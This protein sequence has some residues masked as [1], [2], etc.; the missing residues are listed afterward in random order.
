MESV[1]FSSCECNQLSLQIYENLKYKKHHCFAN[2]ELKC[3]MVDK[4]Y[5]VEFQNSMGNKQE[6]GT[7][8]VIFLHSVGCNEWL[9]N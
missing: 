3:E 4:T 2:L 6:I 9:I 5:I 8:R 7:N 1:N